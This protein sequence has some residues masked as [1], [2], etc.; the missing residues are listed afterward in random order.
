MKLRSGTVVVLGI[1]AFMAAGWLLYRDFIPA[2]W[3][4][5]FAAD[6]ALRASPDPTAPPPA[7]TREAT[8]RGLAANPYI[9]LRK[10]VPF[11][12]D[13]LVVV[14][15]KGDLRT[16]PGLQGVVW[17]D[18]APTRYPARMADDP[19]YQL[20]VLV[21]G[22]Q[23]VADELFYTFWADLSALAGPDGFTPET[24]IFT[25]VV[26]GGRYVLTP[27]AASALSVCP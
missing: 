27:V 13:R 2:T 3:L 22:D 20:I 11:D 12:W 16:A 14:P 15:S 26:Q 9:C 24:A 19:R 25:A 4:R 23:V 10:L 7:D 8:P 5:N 21:K 1:A 17:P 6:I 18:D